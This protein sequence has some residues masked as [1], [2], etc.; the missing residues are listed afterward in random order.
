M[1]INKKIQSPQLIS[2]S[3]ALTDFSKM[4]FFEQLDYEFFQNFTSSHTIKSYRSDIKQ[5]F[6]L[7]REMVQGL[8]SLNSIEKIHVINFRNW[9]EFKSY[10]PKTINR[11]LSAVSSYLDF[12]VEK[13]LMEFNPC[14]QLKRPKQQ[15]KEPTQDLSDDDILKVLNALPDHSPSTALH[16]AVLYTL[17][18]TGIRKSELIYLKG[19][20]YFKQGQHQVIRVYAKGGKI[21]TKV[22]HPSCVQVLEDYLLWMKEQGRV[23][24]QEHWFFQPTKNPL[25]HSVNS[26]VDS[27]NK[28]LRPSSIDYIVKMACKRAGV[29]GRYSP[30]SARASYIGSALEA[31]HDIWKVSLDVGHASVKTTEIYNKRRQKLKDSPAYNLGFLDKVKVDQE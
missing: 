10:A 11:K 29:F 22:L 8:P 19:K 28:P 15:V 31:G 7:L 14:S 3:Q 5:F 27:L 23:I 30:H 4:D 18:T 6:S 21:L 12:L 24:E 17:F 2:S 25:K 16:R 13:N 26:G 1:A 20:D 9:L